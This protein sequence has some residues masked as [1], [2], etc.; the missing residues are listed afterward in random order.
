[1]FQV[2]VGSFTA[3]SLLAGL[4]PSA[5]ILIGTRVLQ[6]LAGGLINPAGVGPGAAVVPRQRARPRVRRS[7]TTVGVAAA[8]PLVGGGLLALGGVHDGWRQEG[9]FVNI[10]IGVLVNLSGREPIR[11]ARLI[12][13]AVVLVTALASGTSAVATTSPAGSPEGAAH[14]M[15]WTADASPFRLGFFDE[16]WVP[17]TLS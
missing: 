7:G 3:T 8:G 2:G 12:T 5:G 6:G 16:G 1:M 11:R 10:P 13:S 9:L 15:T 17:T 4:A 14:S